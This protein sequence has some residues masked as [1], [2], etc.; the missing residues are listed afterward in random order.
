MTIQYNVN[1][2]L[3]AVMIGGGGNMSDVFGMGR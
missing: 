2:V 1:K 3:E